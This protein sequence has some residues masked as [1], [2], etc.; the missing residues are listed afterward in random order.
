MT[1]LLLFSVALATFQVAT[2]LDGTW[3]IEVVD[4]IPVLPEAP[5]TVTFRAA[6]VHGQS[7]C[8]LF[9]GTLAV[10]GTTLRVHGLLTTMRACD[11]ARM[12]QER[13]FLALLRSA[14]RYEILPDGRLRLTN[15]Q[16]KALTAARQ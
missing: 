6:R 15:E 12:D 1:W 14:T 3:K 16:K 2:P 11:T 8:N 5:M 9:Q 10:D 7:S 4:N 13:E